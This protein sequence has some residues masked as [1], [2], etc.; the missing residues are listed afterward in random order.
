MADRGVVG[1]RAGRALFAPDRAGR[2]IRSRSPCSAQSGEGKLR[3]SA[4]VFSTRR[5]G[6][7]S[8]GRPGAARGFSPS[9]GRAW[10]AIE[11]RLRLV[12]RIRWW[13]ATD[14][15]V[16]A[17]TLLFTD[18]QERA[19]GRWGRRVAVRRRGDSGTSMKKKKKKKKRGGGGKYDLVVAGRRRKT[20]LAGFGNQNFEPHN[21]VVRVGGPRRERS[22]GFGPTTCSDGGWD[23]R[24][25]KA[26]ARTGVFP[27]CTATPISTKGVDVHRGR[28]TEAS[29]ASRRT[30]EFGTSAQPP[31][32]TIRSAGTT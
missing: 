8:Q 25:P 13:G 4:L 12:K 18:G 23:L 11:V 29:L 9:H 15:A 17:A 27:R 10:D 16:D 7:D 19:P 26:W 14:A 21:W 31:A 30:R 2:P 20:G 22:S 24:P 32:P 28:P 6:R 5:L 1:R 3:F